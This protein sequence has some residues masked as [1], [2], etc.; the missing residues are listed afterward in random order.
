M[1]RKA[2]VA[3]FNK[4]LCVVTLSGQD[5]HNS[6]PGFGDLGRTAESVDLRD[7]IDDGDGDVTTEFV[8]TFGLN[9]PVKFIDRAGERRESSAVEYYC[10]QSDLQAAYDSGIIPNALLC[11]QPGTSVRVTLDFS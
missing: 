7:D 4:A 1:N 9:R 2:I 6:T 5:E 8:L 11:G 10:S 3:R